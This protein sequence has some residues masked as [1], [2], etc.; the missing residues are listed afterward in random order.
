MYVIGYKWAIVS[1][2]P[3]GL[4]LSLG[5]GLKDDSDPG[6]PLGN[7]WLKRFPD[8]NIATIFARGTIVLGIFICTLPWYLMK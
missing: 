5:Y 4:I 3:M 1:L 2:I 8:E 7:F 6:S